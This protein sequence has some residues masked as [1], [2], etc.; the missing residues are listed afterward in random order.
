MKVTALNQIIKATIYVFIAALE[1]IAIYMSGSRGPMLGLM[2]AIYFM[3]LLLSLYWR[4]R[5]MT[6]TIIGLAV[7]GAIFLAIFNMSK[8]PLDALK[9]SPAIGRF[10]NLL[11]PE[12]NSALVRQYIWEGTVKLVGFHDPLKFPDG[13]KDPFN[14]IRP[15]IG[16]GPEAMYVAYNQ[17]YEPQLGQ[18]E[19]RN[20]S[21]D[22]SHNETW[23]SIVITGLAGLIVYL[24]VFSS[25]FYYSIKWQ[26]LIKAEK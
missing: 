8:G 17:F 24:S 3:G 23:D 4:K 25:F 21:P 18:V 6:L 12:S 19:K 13:S 11:N 16:Y 9:S 5:W 22:R 14:F 15:I 26:G 2:A 10:G 7:A 1:L 20:A